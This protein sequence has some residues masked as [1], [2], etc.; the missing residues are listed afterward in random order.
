MI[1]RHDNFKD[2]EMPPNVKMSG[3]QYSQ[4]SRLDKILLDLITG[5]S[6]KAPGSLKDI[7]IQ[8]KKI[9][10]DPKSCINHQTK[11]TKCPLIQ[12]INVERCDVIKV[13]LESKADPF[14]GH[15]NENSPLLYSM[16]RQIG[17][18]NIDDCKQIQL[19][20]INQAFEHKFQNQ[21]FL[22]KN[23][24]DLILH[25]SMRNSQNEVFDLLIEYGC[26]IDNLN[27]LGFMPVHEMVYL[28]RLKNWDSKCQEKILKFLSVE[29]YHETM[30][31]RNSKTSKVI[32]N[33]K[34][35]ESKCQKGGFTAIQL[36][37]LDII[38]TLKKESETR[39]RITDVC[40]K[41]QFDNKIV[42]KIVENRWGNIDSNLFFVEDIVVPRMWEI[43]MLSR[44]VSVGL[45]SL[46]VNVN[47]IL[48]I[49]D[50]NSMK[51]IMKMFL[52]AN[53]REKIDYLS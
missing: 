2:L 38:P 18:K 52:N 35:C 31:F 1:N 21:E 13:L 47:S 28:P 8:I 14:I 19:L 12:A 46:K 10:D 4:L 6:I 7:I 26:G 30:W 5:T 48:H 34:E 33:I 42:M 17:I 25:T 9:E 32:M 3:Y 23:R 15:D 37:L 50:E 36:I 43:M 24:L 53:T 44:L 41:H 20:L 11:L 45:A 22:V 27:P 29:K 51:I 16:H 39:K 40:K 49:L